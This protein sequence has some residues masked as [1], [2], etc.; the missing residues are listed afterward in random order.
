MDDQD[1][2]DEQEAERRMNDALRRA[3]SMPPKPHKPKASEQEGLAEL[4]IVLF[5]L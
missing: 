5:K 4:P 2:V 1:K 3:F